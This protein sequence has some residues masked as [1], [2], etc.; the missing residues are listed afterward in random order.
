MGLATKAASLAGLINVEQSAH[1]LEKAALH[2]EP[3]VR[4]AAAA[5]A[6]HL[7]SIPTSLAMKLLNDSDPGVR[8][9]TLKAV[10]VRQPAGVKAR[11]QEIITNDPDVGLRDRARRI[12]NQLP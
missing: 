9:W 10:E 4:V 1:V 7:T 2:P 8:K 11:V 3:V 5:S 6:R 12:I